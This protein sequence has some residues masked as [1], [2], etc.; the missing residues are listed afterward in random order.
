M[1]N[2][3]TPVNADILEELLIQ[4]QYNPTKRNFIVK[5]FREGFSIKYRGRK[6][7]QQRSNN[8]RFNVGNELQLWNKVMKEVKLKRFAGPY[9]TPPFGNF[10]Q[11]PI[12]LVPKDNGVDTRLIFHLSHPR[13]K[14]NSK[15][16]QYTSHGKRIKKSAEP[17][18]VN[19]CTPKKY[20]KV[21]YPD[22]N[23]AIRHCIEEGKN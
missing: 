7:L 13:L 1:T 9:D 22:F 8:L 2:V 10:I 23:E 21:Q 18:S 6:N 14:S 16:E 11:S 12:G 19:A 5:G 15:I 4:S 3:I 20:C 17:K